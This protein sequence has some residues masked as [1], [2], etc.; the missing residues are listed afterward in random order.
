MPIYVYLLMIIDFVRLT[1]FQHYVKL[2]QTEEHRLLDA[3][4]N[5]CQK[6][7]NQLT[8][9]RKNFHE[10]GDTHIPADKQCFGQ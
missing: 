3:K 9:L 2:Q 5:F 4:K 1:M 10:K 7:I 8:K 6:R